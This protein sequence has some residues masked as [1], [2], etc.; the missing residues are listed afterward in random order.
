[1]RIYLLSVCY[2]LCQLNAQTQYVNLIDGRS[3][4]LAGT[5]EA[6]GESSIGI[7]NPAGLATNRI[8]QFGLHYQN[9]FM[10]HELGVQSICA[11]IPVRRGSFAVR[12][13][14]FGTNALNESKFTVSYGHS[15]NSWLAAGID[16]NYHYLSI[17]ALNEKRSAITGN[18]GFV[19]KP[20]EELSIGINYLNP[21]NIGYNYDYRNESATSLQAGIS[22]NEI[23][24]F[25]I[26]G[27]VNWV[28]FRWID[29]AMG[30]EVYLTGNLIVRGGIKIP[31]SLSYSFGT[32]LY[33]S[34][35]RFDMGFEQHPVLGLSSS[36]SIIIQIS[37][38]AKK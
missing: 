13:N 2:F 14:Y 38:H 17:Q 5:I 3:I 37:R 26:A 11:A 6:T 21:A 35:I 9:R 1:M 27:K 31:S 24:K 36:A 16:L 23:G 7:S 4:A 30:A 25:L 10:L 15:I 20:I 18:I 19:I 8:L 28:D 22:Y 32:G 29:V 34:W 12:I 33:Y